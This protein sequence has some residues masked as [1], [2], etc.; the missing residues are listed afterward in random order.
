M[1][2]IPNRLV[3][4][5]SLVELKFVGISKP[6]KPHGCD[7]CA[8]PNGRELWVV[9]RGTAKSFSG[10]SNLYT[11]F[12]SYEPESCYTLRLSESRL[13]KSRKVA[14]VVYRSDKWCDNRKKTDY[15]HRFIRQP[16]AWATNLKKPGFIRI[17]GGRIRVKEAGICG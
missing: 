4:L 5:G 13:L 1:A 11:I 9:P 10:Q 6:Y 7:L 2:R 3:C 16:T 12:T 15:I 14:H 17:S 8:S